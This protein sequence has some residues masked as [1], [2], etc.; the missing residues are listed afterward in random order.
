M[1]YNQLIQDTSVVKVKLFLNEVLIGLR[2]K[3]NISAMPIII[4]EAGMTNRVPIGDALQK[5]LKRDVVKRENTQLLEI[6]SGCGNH[7][8]YFSKLFPHIQ[9]QPSDLQD[10]NVHSIRCH[11]DADPLE[12]VAEPLL[13]DVCNPLDGWG[14]KNGTYDF[15]FN[16]KMVHILPWKG[17]ENLFA[18]AR[19]ILKPCGRL[20]M[21]G[22]FAVV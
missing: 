7:V 4:S 5:Y 8:M 1:K 14:L 11:L 16:S 21:Y 6:A 20:F 18:S 10:K 17:T 19:K 12:N 3:L 13:I 22:S 2:I 9:W 15:M